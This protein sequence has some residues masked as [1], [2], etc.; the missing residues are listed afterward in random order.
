MIAFPALQSPTYRHDFPADNCRGDVGPMS[1]FY[2]SGH[3]SQSSA[4]KAPKFS[5]NNNHLSLYPHT[6]NQ[7][8]IILVSS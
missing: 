6:K 1:H 4:S 8:D 3:K 2:V 7:S 5:M